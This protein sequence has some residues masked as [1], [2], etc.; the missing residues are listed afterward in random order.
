[1][2]SDA[3]AAGGQARVVIGYQRGRERA[4]S[5]TENEEDG[6]EAPHLEIMLHEG[7]P[8]WVAYANWCGRSGIID[9]LRIHECL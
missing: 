6:E 9:A 3:A 2:R 4:K 1:M 5:E 7:V 8:A